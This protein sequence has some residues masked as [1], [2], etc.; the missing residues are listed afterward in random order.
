M[1][2][3]KRLDLYSEKKKSHKESGCDQIM[4]ATSAVLGYKKSLFYSPDISKDSASDWLLDLS[5]SRSSGINLRSK[6]N[7]AH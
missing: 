7:G 1:S 6:E 4:H 5:L 2:L 3:K